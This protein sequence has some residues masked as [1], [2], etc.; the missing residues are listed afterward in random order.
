M[1]NENDDRASDRFFCTAVI[2]VMFDLFICDVTQHAFTPYL[3]G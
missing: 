3:H 2:F 1:G